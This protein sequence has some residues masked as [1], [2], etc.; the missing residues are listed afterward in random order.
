MITTGIIIGN[1]IANIGLIQQFS[2]FSVL[3]FNFKMINPLTSCPLVTYFIDS[4]R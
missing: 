2:I 1:I 4:F 3:L